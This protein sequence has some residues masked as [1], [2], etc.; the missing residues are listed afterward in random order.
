MEVKLYDVLVLISR[1]RELWNLISCMSVIDHC[2][3]FFTEV[4]LN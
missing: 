4:G 3:E 2:I 1:S